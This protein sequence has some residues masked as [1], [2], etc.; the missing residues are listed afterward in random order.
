MAKGTQ[1]YGFI[2]KTYNPIKGECQHGCNY[3]YMIGLRNHYHHD[4]TLR[5]DQ[6]ELRKG[7]GKGHFIFL[8][9]ATDVCAANVPS[10]WI[11]PVLDHLYDYPENQYLLQ[12]KNPSRFYEFM[13]HKFFVDRKDSIVLCTTIESNIDHP[14]VSAAPVMAERIA[15]MQYYANL[16]YRIMITVEP[17]MKFSDP[18]QFADLLASVNPFQVNIGANSSNLVKLS[19]PDKTEVLALIQELEARNITVYQK[20]NL[21]RLMK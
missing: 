12:S 21:A 2:D 15:A 4:P 6:K 14:S 19:E 3:C 10:E 11:I 20:S 13:G 17:V 16:G 7:L 5:L 9:S 1:M 18:V 8:G